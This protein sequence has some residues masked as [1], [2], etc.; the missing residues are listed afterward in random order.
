MRYLSLWFNLQ[1]R[2][3]E[4]VKI[5]TS[6]ASRA[7]EALHMLGNSISGMNQLCLRQTYLGMV[8][9][10]ATYGSVA[11]WD[12][13]SSTVKNTLECMQNKALHFITGAFK[14]TPI[15]ALEIESSIP[16]INITLDYYMECYATCTQ[17][18]NHSNPV[19]C[20]IPNHHREDILIQLTPLPCFPP[21]PKNLIAP[22]LIR[23]HKAKIKKTMT[24]QLICMAKGIT[25]NMEC[26][27]PHAEPPWHRLEYDY[28]IHD[29]ICLYIPENRAGTSVK[30]EWA[31]DHANLYDEY[32]GD[33]EV[34][35]IYTD[36]SLSYN[37]GIHRTGYSIV[38]YRNGME[39]ASVKGSM[40]EHVEVYDTKMRALEVAV[41]L[42][43]KLINSETSAL[44][45][46]IIITTD[47]TGALQQIFQGSP[48]K[49]QGS[50]TAFHKHVLDILDQHENT[51]F[52]LTWC[53]GHFN[54]E[55][56]E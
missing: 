43:H 39:I 16:P 47:N 18:L 49:A 22:Y 10:I 46:K 56:N 31:E 12:G 1:L 25:N 50:S 51:Q 28:D 52:A 14:T 41:E 54:I 6:K 13:K 4:H 17:R 23:Q 40:G 24:T 21:P 9:P 53:P 29:R 11:F 48:G 5:V 34:M 42:I 20:C 27:S 45:S 7:T 33:S 15:H 26:I 38:A 55:G 8:L 30:T 19:M 3:H 32:K 36:G 35:F 37:N 2:F 44:P